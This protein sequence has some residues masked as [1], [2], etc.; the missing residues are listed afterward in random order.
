[1]RITHLEAWAAQNPS[2]VAKLVLYLDGQPLPDELPRLDLL[3]RGYLVFVLARTSQTKDAWKTLMGKPTSLSRTFRVTVGPEGAAPFESDARLTLHLFRAGWIWALSVISFVLAL[4]LI[5]K[6]DTASRLLR[7]NA[8]TKEDG[9]YSLARVQ[10]AWWFVSVVVVYIGIYAV[11]G[12]YDVLSGSVL[13]LIG[14]SSGTAAFAT[15]VDSTGRNEAQKRVITLQDEMQKL[16]IAALPGHPESAEHDGDIRSMRDEID[17]MER[18][19][20]PGS[21]GFPRDILTFAGSETGLHRLQM[22]VWTLVLWV[23]FIIETYRTLAMPDFSGELLALM[24]ISSG[25]Y[26]GFKAATQ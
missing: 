10:M 18:I 5:K 26:V 6:W 3:T 15:V 17:R 14:I 12:Y 1:L 7:N 9:P 25:T 16:K 2:G 24:G 4:I 23:I 22:I 8:T 13:T 19:V 11:T 21:K 20:N